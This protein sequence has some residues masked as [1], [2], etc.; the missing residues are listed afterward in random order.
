MV[1]IYLENWVL[2]SMIRVEM[3]TVVSLDEQNLFGISPQDQ[4]LAALKTEPH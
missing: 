3:P 2:E 4:C 1:L